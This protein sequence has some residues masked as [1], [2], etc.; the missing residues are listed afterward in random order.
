MTVPVLEV[1][2]GRR[3]PAALSALLAAPGPQWR[4]VA[5]DERPR[6]DPA[7]A[8]L[9]LLA[10][11]P[12]RLPPRCAVWLGPGDRLLEPPNRTWDQ[13][14]PVVELPC[15]EL[16]GRV[17]SPVL[18][19]PAPAGAG[20]RRV[21]LPFTRRR[22]RQLRGLPDGL[23]LS[24]SGAGHRWGS[25]PADRTS[26]AVPA[27]SLPTLHALAAAAVVT[28]P[29]V[30]EAL[31]WG[32]PVVTDPATAAS[33]GLVHGEHVLVATSDGW[34]DALTA[35]L[36]DD[37]LAA[38]LARAGHRAVTER[39][40]QRAAEHLAQ[41]LGFDVRPASPPPGTKLVTALDLLDT[42]QRAHIR[43]R[44]RQHTVDL[45]GAVTYGWRLNEEDQ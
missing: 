21:V 15:Q 26:A 24:G 30:L 44:V 11:L 9:Y 25:T 45:P 12:R 23:V 38:T 33:C 14:H 40:P 8:H 39:A 32:C 22:W 3:P 6:P 13:L 35:L 2:V 31:R 19:A 1:H 34:T 36:A 37:A 17:G 27:N 5:G 7:A 16:P 18:V 20:D 4:P 41:A 10:T 43:E 29:D 28:G 42:P